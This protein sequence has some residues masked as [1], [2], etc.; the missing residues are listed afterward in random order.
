[1]IANIQHC[2]ATVH[3]RCGGVCGSSA[4]ALAFDCSA[5]SSRAG[6]TLVRIK[7]PK[8]N[9][10]PCKSAIFNHLPHACRGVGGGA[11][12]KARE[13]HMIESTASMWP[14]W[15]RPWRTRL[16]LDH[17]QQFKW[18][19]MHFSQCCAVHCIQQLV[20]SHLMCRRQAQSREVRFCVYLPPSR[21][22]RAL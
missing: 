20:S 14:L 9:K 2:P 16:P 15:R 22:V 10:V 3:Q 13:L 12:E 17:V 21:S 19:R 18:I 7:S 4:C 11:R 1:M 8:D 5:C 6:L